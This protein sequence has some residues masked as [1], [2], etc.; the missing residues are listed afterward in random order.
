MHSRQYHTQRPSLPAQPQL[1]GY[2]DERLNQLRRI[3]RICLRKGMDFDEFYRDIID[4][5]GCRLHLN[6]FWCDSEEYSPAELYNQLRWLG[7]GSLPEASLNVFWQ[8]QEESL[9][10]ESALVR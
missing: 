6:P 2:V 9:L 5:A 3:I 8:L 4:P 7:F 10:S 1:L